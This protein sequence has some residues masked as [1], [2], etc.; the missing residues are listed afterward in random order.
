VGTHEFFSEAWLAGLLATGVACTA[1]FGIAYFA[2]GLTAA[3]RRGLS[4]LKSRLQ[5]G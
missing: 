3:E 2:V 1:A 4:G 5:A